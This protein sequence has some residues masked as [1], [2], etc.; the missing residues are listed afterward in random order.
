MVSREDVQPTN[1][2]ILKQSFRLFHINFHLSLD[3][4][5]NVLTQLAY[6]AVM[7]G[8]GPCIFALNPDLAR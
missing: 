7:K 3:Q 1:S 2:S 6:G 4:S 5:L 8:S